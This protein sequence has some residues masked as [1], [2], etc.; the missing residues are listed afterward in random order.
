MNNRPRLFKATLWSGVAVV[1]AGFLAFSY[2][3]EVDRRQH[4]VHPEDGCL[5]YA[6]PSATLLLLNDK[7]DPLT[8]DQPHRWRAAIEADL[9]PLKPGS[10]VLVGAI[11]PTAPAELPLRKLCVPIAGRGAGAARLQLAFD[12][13]IDQIGD[14]LLHS[15]STDKSA[16][17]E[18]IL[19]AV[20]H[21]AFRAPTESRRIEIAS[22]LLENDSVSAYRA[23]RF[24][25][26]T[27]PGEPLKGISIRFTVLRNVRDARFQTR[28]LID[29]WTDWARRAGAEGVEVDA[30]WIGLTAR[31]RQ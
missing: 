1:A 17:S 15:P 16:I 19:T 2:A 31:D 14:E 11:G 30:P 9:T 4:A 18:T 25:L 24:A 20:S 8:G 10:V 3:T 22:D 28:Q 7:T 27:P 6:P 21:P 29:A 26:P 13:N 12:H 23:Q 5:A